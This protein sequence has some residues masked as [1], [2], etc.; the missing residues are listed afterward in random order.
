M[1]IGVIIADDELHN[2]E[3]LT[4]VLSEFPEIEI[5][6]ICKDGFE[7]VTAVQKQSPDILFLDITMP[8]LSGFEVLE[9][10]GDSAPLVVFVT[11][12]DEHAL[13]AFETS[14]VDYVLKP[15]SRERIRRS[16]EKCKGSG[17]GKKVDYS[18]L[19]DSQRANSSPVNRI[20]IKDGGLI[21]IVP[22]DEIIYMKAE[23][24]YV[25]IITEAKSYLKLD[26]ISALES[27]L[28][29]ELFCR[30]HRSYLLNINFLL[31]LEPYGKETYQ[32]ILKNGVKIPVS[33]AGFHTLPWF[34]GK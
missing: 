24:D 10:L 27:S 13:R 12:Y 6:A 14:A 5:L 34:K 30:V 9:L 8:R 32:A 16:I 23:D 17:L 25:S 1:A 29:K 26:R 19:V 2:R 4:S 18:S 22:V 33:A 11:A 31:R 15:I 21:H 20:L 3:T 28:D 7:T